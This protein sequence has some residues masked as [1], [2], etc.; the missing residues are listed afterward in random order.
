MTTVNPKTQDAAVR[1]PLNLN[2]PV[3]LI[4]MA[5]VFRAG[6]QAVGRFAFNWRTAPTS[7]SWY[8]A[9]AE[10]HLQAL[11]EGIWLDEKSGCPHAACVMANMAIILDSQAAGTLVDD[12]PGVKTGVDELLKEYEGKFKGEV[13]A[14]CAVPENPN[15]HPYP[16]VTP[17]EI[18]EA[19]ER[20]ERDRRQVEMQSLASCGAPSAVDY[21]RAS[22]DQQVVGYVGRTPIY[23]DP[24][25]FHAVTGHSPF[26][27]DTTG[28]AAATV[29]VVQ[30]SICKKCE[31]NPCLCPE[32]FYPPNNFP[33][34]MD[35]SKT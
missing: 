13:K 27:V 11:K 18:R 32:Y 30:C 6:L 25:Q 20:G 29:T 14:Q 34:G 2:P 22:V 10:R 12:S 21:L 16:P 28:Q 9:A 17:Q 26:T 7:L 8:S 35:P 5:A 3:A 19:V 4:H 24:H 31:R 23:G 15:L 1:V 33:Y